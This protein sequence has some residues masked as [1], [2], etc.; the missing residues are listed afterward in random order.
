[1]GKNKNEVIPKM[2]NI[3][4]NISQN[5]IEKYERESRAYS[6]SGILQKIIKGQ[7]LEKNDIIFPGRNNRQIQT[8]S[9][10]LMISVT[11]VPFVHSCCCSWPLGH[12]LWTQLYVTP[13]TC[14]WTN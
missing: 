14:Q 9:V 10:Q 1:M 7:T 5:D 12:F 6:D 8:Q 2:K 11:R 13:L 4:Y 3:I